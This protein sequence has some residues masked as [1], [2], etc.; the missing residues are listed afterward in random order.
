MR[1][2]GHVKTYELNGRLQDDN[3]TFYGWK[4]EFWV[5]HQPDYFLKLNVYEIP[6][7]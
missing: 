2:L 1:N 6:T 4:A 7:N 5:D 3:V